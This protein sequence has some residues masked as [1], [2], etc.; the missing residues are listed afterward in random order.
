MLKLDQAGHGINRK[1]VQRLMRVMGIEALVPRPARQQTRAR[2]QIYLL[3]LRGMSITE[4]DHVLGQQHRLHSDGA[5]LSVSG[6][7]YGLGQPAAWRRACGTRSNTGFLHRSITRRSAGA[8]PARRESQ[9]P[10][11]ALGSPA[12]PS[13]AGSGLRASRFRWTRTRSFHGQYFSSSGCN[14][15]SIKYKE[16]ASESLC[17]RHEA[18]GSVGSSG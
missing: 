2:P 9:T 11:R 4:P 7:D 17:R 12:Q 5:G 14:R 10:I 1:R 6:G 8:A 16:D 3:L 18:R 13:P 15:I